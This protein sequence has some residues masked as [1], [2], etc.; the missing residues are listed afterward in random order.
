MTMTEAPLTNYRIVGIRENWYQA[1]PRAPRQPGGSCWHCGTGIANE[2]VIENR[3][4]G[5]IHTV[6]TTCAERVGLDAAELKAMLAEKFAQERLEASAAYRRARQAEHEARD[7]RDTELYGP[8]GTARRWRSG[9]RCEPCYA[10]APHG[11]FPKYEN[12]C[13]CGPC[14][15]SM[16]ADDRYSVHT[17]RVVL[18]DL[19]SGRIVALGVNWGQYGA[20]WKA[21]GGFVNAHPKR[22]GTIAR[23]GYTE[24]EIPVLVQRCGKSHDTWYRP[25][26]A[27][28]SPL[29]DTWG[30]PV[31]HP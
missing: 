16:L 28:A 11:S 19:D 6:G 8:H 31:P 20:Y 3:E 30:E 12:G 24:A 26:A 17:D 25:V 14:L 7:A 23:K 29:V 13:T 9:C 10:A 15:D 27:L 18:V 4:T 22:R 5:E 1:D 2:V 21:G